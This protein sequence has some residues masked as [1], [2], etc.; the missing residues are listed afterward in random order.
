MKDLEKTEGKEPLVPEGRR[1][2]MH[3]D[4]NQF[5]TMDACVGGRRVA[6][7]EAMVALHRRKN[8]NLVDEDSKEE[9]ETAEELVDV[10]SMEARM[11]DELKND[12]E[13]V[14]KQV[15]SKKSRSP[16]PRARADIDIDPCRYDDAGKNSFC[17]KIC[18]GTK[19]VI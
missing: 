8:V 5:G 15:G 2:S 19:V 18:F 12:A 4:L 9:G 6:V 11:R 16:S 14:V 13:E 17:W 10:T 3:Y 7:A 1:W